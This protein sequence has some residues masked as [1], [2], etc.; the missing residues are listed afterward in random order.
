MISSATSTEQWQ[1]VTV[2]PFVDGQIYDQVGGARFAH[3]SPATGQT[4]FS[5]PEGSAADVD[6]AVSS[7][8]DGFEDQRWRGMPPSGRKAVLYRLANMITAEA[9]TLDAL[10]AVEMG[11]P[12]SVAFGN[13]LAAAAIFRFAAEAVDKLTG[14]VY[15][16]D[17]NS[18]VTQ[19]RVPRGVVAAVVP[20][21]FPAYVAALKAAPAL[22]AGNCVVLK[23]SELSPRSAIRIAELAVEAGL[24]AGVLNIVPGLGSTVGQALGRHP[25]VDMLTFTGSTAVGKLMLEYAARSNMKAVMAECGGKSPQ[26]IFEDVADLEAT[27]STVARLLLTNQGQVCSVGSRLLVQRS[28]QA[29]V[30]EM[31]RA[32]LVKVVMGDPLTPQTT[33]GPVASA[34][35]C[36]R[37]MDYIESAPREGAQLV[38][39]GNRALVETGGFFVEPTLFCGVDPRS[40]VAQEEIFGPVL[41]VIPFDTEAEAIALANGT[42]YGLTAYVW[43]TD[44]SRAMRMANGIRSSVRLN[45]AVPSGEGA[46]LAYSYE[47]VQQ[48]GLGTE[49]GLAGIEAY[50]RRQLVWINH[51]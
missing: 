12:V 24:P 20:W 48:S 43:T 3:V 4:I 50:L 6:R 10:D 11:K 5:I 36:A 49:G 51:A 39:G 28:V 30:V 21:N 35:Q 7:A 26:I 38:V 47:P 46:G 41:S 8:R 31:L 13:A 19:R 32:E 27:A 37:V 42:I 34:A 22:A 1:A 16:S 9:A 17:Q 44:L 33:F 15:V 18:F 23:P 25:D 40:R 29:R 45:A 14:D 2:A